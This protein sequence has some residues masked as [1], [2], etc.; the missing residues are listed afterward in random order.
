[1]VRLYNQDGTE[2][3]S[4]KVGKRPITM[5]ERDDLLYVLNFNDTIL[6]IVNLAEKKVVRTVSVARS[7]L[8]AVLYGNELWMGGHGSGAEVNDGVYVYEN[9][10]VKQEVLAPQMPVSFAA[11]AASIYI[12]SHG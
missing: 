9:G 4:V 12:L 7:S 2:I 1:A 8:G 5:I 10:A 3:A 6:S 11:D